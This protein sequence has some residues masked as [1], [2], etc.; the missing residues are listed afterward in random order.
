MENFIRGTL[1]SFTVLSILLKCFP[2]TFGVSFKFNVII[3]NDKL[4]HQTN[5]NLKFKYLNPSHIYNPAFHFYT[6]KNQI[7]PI[8]A[9]CVPLTKFHSFVCDHIM[10]YTNIGI[11]FPNISFFSYINLSIFII[12]YFNPFVFARYCLNFQVHLSFV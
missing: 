4:I 11:H 8:S 5:L 9:V 1:F 3:D 6:N 10:S 12:V 2:F 7:T